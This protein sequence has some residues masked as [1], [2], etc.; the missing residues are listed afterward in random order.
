M[1][2]VAIVLSERFVS[3][4]PMRRYVEY[5][6]YGPAADPAKRI[7]W[8]RPLT[9]DEAKNYTLKNVFGDWD[10]SVK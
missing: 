6:N 1:K 9:D 8:S 2:P 5:K 4:D 7:Y 10:I 3:H